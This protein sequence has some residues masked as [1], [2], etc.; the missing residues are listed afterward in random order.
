MT[1]SHLRNIWLLA[2]L[3]LATSLHALGQE[4]SQYDAGTPP[5]H[6]A[7]VSALGS[8]TAVDLG[9]VNLS[10]GALNFKIPL[11]T[12]G[13]RGFSVPLTLN[14]SSKVWSASKDTDTDR[15]NTPFTATYADYANQDGFM[16]F[17]QRVGPGWSIGAT[18]II[19]NRIVRIKQL[20]PQP[21][22]NVPGCYMFTL[23]KLTVMLPD[24]GEIE[25]RDDA[26]DG[27]PLSSDCG[28]WSAGLSRGRRWHA[29]DGSGTI[30]ISDGDNEAAKR[31]GDLSGV[32]ITAD[33][34]R[35]RFA[36][37]RC[38]S[39]TDRNGN[40]ID[41]TYTDIPAKV[42]Y[43]DQLGRITKIE[44]FVADPDAPSVT[45]AVL[46]TI[47][48]YSG[49]HYLKLKRGVMR[50]NYRSDI[51]A[52]AAV[53]N[54]TYDPLSKGYST[55]CGSSPTNLFPH[56][57]GAFVQRI[58]DQ[59]VLT[60]V[61]LPDQRSL[62]FRYNLFGEVAEAQ[63]PTGGKLWYDYDSSNSLPTGNSNLWEIGA[64]YHTEVGDVDRALVE[65]RVFSG[66]GL[67][68]T[69]NYLYT[70]NYVSV[71]ASS[72][73]EGTL[74]NERHLFLPGYRYTDAN[75]SI[76][77]AHD[78]TFYSLWS[79]GVEWRTELRNAD[80]SA[81]L[82]AVEKEWS[83]RAQ[84][85]WGS[86]YQEQPANDNR[87]NEERRY[88][89]N[90]LMAKVHTSYDQYNN[91][92]QVDEYDY[93]QSLK[94]RTV[95]SYFNGSGY[96]S[97]DAIHLLRL[98]ETQTVY[99][100]SSVQKAQTVTEY[101]VY[102]ND[103]NRDV[104]TSYAS[105]SQHDASYDAAK[106]T[107]GN[108]TRVGTWLNTTGSFIYAYPRYDILGNV[109]AV[110]DARGNVSTISFADDF[111]DGSNPGSTAQNPATP[112]YALPTLLTSPPPLAGQPAHTARSQYNYATGLLTGFRNRNSVVTQT[113]YN[114]PFDRPTLIKAA[115]GIS[116][117]ESH[118]KI[119]YAPATTPF[120]TTLVNNDVLTATDQTAVDDAELRSWT[121]TDGF[122]RTT[123]AWRRDPQGDVAVITN[124]DALSRARQVSNPFRP[125][126]E[127]A[128]YS[129]TTYDLLGR[130]TAV[131][132]VDGG[133]GEHEL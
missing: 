36:G 37:T 126:T 26:Y 88:L 62:R 2:F 28:G 91:P 114:D 70:S 105:V 83:Q 93:D 128:A 95:M 34:T 32:V 16:D 66:S 106:T 41:I 46:V 51:T 50:A 47:P 6:A 27:A 125:A 73:T 100:G 13:G 116:G 84:L 130:I 10:N 115:L 131:T 49:N 8:Y 65:Q 99:D 63:L 45:L 82:S 35:Y 96:Q 19:F 110:K 14:Y 97:N 107:R 11:A 92:I 67:Q 52:P 20:P 117:S 40:R 43:R 79:T 119:Y 108:P 103:G 21:G 132:G 72:P 31:F 102:T 122:A 57:Y 89:E 76:T 113:I 61:V 64:D 54:G 87:V 55:W 129:T 3:L 60:E 81:V 133:G 17:F 15:T 4:Q 85:S 101:D 7:G 127:T 56:S 78:G 48:G 23:P 5:Q 90:G 58:D 33:G 75:G 74:R 1:H 53:C 68:T 112:T 118:T 120:G 86:Y 109:V 77:G 104:L 22:S 69:W 39:I 25:F 111:G 98:P 121:V 12:V 59:Q 30:Y 18:P 42:E 123:Q 124:Y 24:R 44:Q 29:T 80:G 94:R 9:S 71:F 38:S